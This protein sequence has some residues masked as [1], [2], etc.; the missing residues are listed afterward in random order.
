MR[1]LRTIPVLV[2]IAQ[3]MEELCPDA[4][5]INYVNP[6]CMNQWAITRATGIKTV[7]LCHSV[8]HT[9]RELSHDIDVPIEDI[10]YL[11][12]FWTL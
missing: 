1:G 10:N 11:G 8:P 5:F 2:D 12:S 3:D 7:G 6:M 4:L 9:A